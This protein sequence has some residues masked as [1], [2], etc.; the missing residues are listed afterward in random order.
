MGRQ[1][2]EFVHPKQRLF[3]S[4][5]VD[6]MKMAGRHHNMAPM[7]KKLMELVDLDEPT[8]L[9]DHEN[10]GCTQRECKPNE[11]K[12]NQYKEMFESRISATAPENY[13]DGRNRTQK[14]LHGPTICEDMLKSALNDIANWRTKYRAIVHSFNALLG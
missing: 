10:S 4:I 3:L 12:V 7:L 14:L 8:S 1:V 9:L 11:D 13:Q 5:Y 6:D 2:E